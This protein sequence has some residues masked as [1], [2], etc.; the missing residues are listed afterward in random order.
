MEISSFDDLVTAGLKES[1]PQRLL[2]VL[3]RAVPVN[4]GIDQNPDGN[5]SG[6]G[7]LAPVMATDLE[8]TE[9]LRLE[10]LIAEADSL[11]Q[12]WDFIMVSSLSRADGRLPQSSEAEPYLQQMT[13]AIVSGA[14]LSRY[15]IFTRSGDP[16]ALQ[17]L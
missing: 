3:L 17:A 10:T 16:A 1:V 2:L 5:I 15:A 12:P 14:D 6:S 9:T 11:G 13:D 4:N 8:L 7:T